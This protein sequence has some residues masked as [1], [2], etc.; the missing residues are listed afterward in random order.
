MI[1]CLKRGGRSEQPQ[2]GVANEV[3]RATSGSEVP[4]KDLKGGVGR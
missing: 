3:G 4:S 1:I 2:S